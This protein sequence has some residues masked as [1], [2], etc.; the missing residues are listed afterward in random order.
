MLPAGSRSAQ[1]ANPVRLLGR[2]LHDLD[3]A[4][5]QP[6][7]RAV[8]ILG[9]QQELP[10]VPFAIISAMTR[11]SSS[12]MPGVGGRRV[13]TMFISGLVRRTDGDPAHVVLP[14]VLADLEAEGVAVEGQRLLPGLRGE[15]SSSGW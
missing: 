2:L 14:D 1:S 12:V 15:G 9:G 7:E 6:L 4:G 13:S 5:L 8:E 10:K 3:A 11:R